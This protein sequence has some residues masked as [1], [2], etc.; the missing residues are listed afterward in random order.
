[1]ALARAGEAVV[2]A[3]LALEAA[4]IARH[5]AA[6]E[7]VALVA[8]PVAE[9]GNAPALLGAPVGEAQGR[10]RDAELDVVALFGEPPGA[11]PQAVPAGVLLVGKVALVADDVALHAE[12][13][14]HQFVAAAVVV[15]G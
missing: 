14:G 2:F 10:E 6:G 11:L 5:R 9:Q 7:L 1:A 15:E 3:P 13:I 4:R 8:R 12:R